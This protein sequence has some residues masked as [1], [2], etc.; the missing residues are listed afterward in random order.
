V[1]RRS[2]LVVGV[3]V[4]ALAVGVVSWHV[5]RSNGQRSIVRVA[6][7]V[8]GTDVD[9]SRR[10]VVESETAVAVDPRNPNVLLA[11]SNVI[12]ERA[13]QGVY[14]STDG[15]RTWRAGYLP[16]PAHACATS[17]PSVA[18]GAGGR[19]YFSFLGLFCNRRHGQRAQ[20][21]VATRA[22]ASAAWQVLP[23]PATRGSKTTLID[24]RPFLAVDT[25][26]ASPH[27]GRLYLGWTRFGVDPAALFTSPDDVDGNFSPVQETVL[28][29]HSD[30][31]GRHWAA[32]RQLA[33][34]GAPLEV[35]LAVAADGTVYAAW[36][37][38]K[39][40]SIWVARSEGT[41][42]VDRTFVAGSV[43]SE[44]RSCGGFRARVRAQPKRCVSPNPVVSVDGSPGP[45]QGDVYVTWGTT[46]LNG[47]QDVYVARFDRSLRPELGVGHVQQVG[48]AEGL[49]GGD[50]FLP[51]SAVDSSTGTLWVC[52][53]ESVGASQ[54]SAR[55]ACTSSDDGGVK[56]TTP[57]FAASRPSDETRKG[58]NRAN[59]Y[60]DYE[61]VAVAA[62]SA[63][64]VWT[65]G[66]SGR[67]GHE[68]VY[69]AR[70]R[71][72]P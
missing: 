66:R 48:P 8:A 72:V 24:D 5:A 18:I 49:R 30:D 62:G 35:R 14:S 47:S 31:G 71:R 59:G 32:P 39:T 2:A 46:A 55:Y 70:L 28:V 60:G 25:G 11:G 69:G 13:P 58:A 27:R 43:V 54:K 3:V 29:S 4:A 44:E 33:G 50:Q 53:Y 61:G 9:V 68:D 21:F 36:R 65:D 67:T 38:Q 57:R 34:Q 52:F 22:N 41:A 20:V 45:R 64:A 23:A 7:V 51:A 12:R 37:E 63:Y 17:D 19:Q 10:R 15:G 1:S 26:A 16:M 56:W 40:G 6:R 42:F